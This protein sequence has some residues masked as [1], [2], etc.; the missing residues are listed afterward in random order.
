MSRK[1]LTVF[2]SFVVLLCARP[3]LAQIASGSSSMSSTHAPRLFVDGIG[4]VTF[5]HEPGGLWGAGVSI[6]ASR[7]VQVLGEAGRLTNV[8]PKS[9][10][11][12]LNSAAETLVANGGSPFIF[13]AT[14]PATYGLGTVRITST[15]THSGLAP[16]VEGGAGFAHVTPNVSAQSA[17]LDATDTLLS[18][19]TTPII[20]TQTKPMFTVGGGLSIQAGK[21][22]AVDLGYR[23]GRILTDDVAVPTN[24]IYAGVRV[25]L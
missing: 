9:M 7:H 17:G 1:S 3:A 22:S 25:G 21:R 12:D 2:F 14:M 24:R 13:T 10:S 16:F 4:G 11:D 19:V 5:S 8:L 6:R 23:Y 18:S 15:P 20:A